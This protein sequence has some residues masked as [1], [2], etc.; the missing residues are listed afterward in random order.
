MVREEEKRIIFEAW[1]LVSLFFYIYFGLE[2][3]SI[4]RAIKMMKNKM[5]F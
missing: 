2:N 1:L 4:T 5:T 3:E